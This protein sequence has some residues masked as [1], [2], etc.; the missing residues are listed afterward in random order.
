M[1]NI[2]F[3]AYVLIV[4][5]LVSLVPAAFAAPT[6]ISPNLSDATYVVG[7][8]PDNLSVGLVM[9]TTECQWQSVPVIEGS[10]VFLYMD[11]TGA[12]GTTYTPS[13]DSAE[14]RYYR[15]KMTNSAGDVSYSD[16]ALITVLNEPTISL[17][18]ASQSVPVGNAA[19]FTAAAS[20]TDGWELTH[21]YWAWGPTSNPA[22]ITGDYS[23]GGLIADTTYNKTINDPGSIYYFY[24]GEYTDTANGTKDITV[25]SNGA[26]AVGYYDNPFTDV[27]PSDWFYSD[28]LYAYNLGLI[29]GMTATTYVPDGNLTIAQSIKLAACMHQYDNT[30]AVTLVNGTVNWYDTYVDYAIGNGIISS[31]T[32]AGQYDD[33]ATRAD[34]VK[35]FY[36][37]LEPSAYTEIHTVPPGAIPD[38][39][40]TDPYGY[41]VYTFYRA[42]ILQGN[43]AN[44]TFAPDSNIKRSEV[45]AITA[46]MMDP[47]NRITTAYLWVT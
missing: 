33:D 9:I 25:Y 41:E 23:S 7:E 18:P 27:S 42:G 15:C 4:C 2:K 38:V 11:I 43:D 17:T 37:A 40:I 44:G 47:A 45:A 32:Y 13:T 20:D 28:V 46:R 35:I 31:S 1:K 29:D 24:V 16:A 22:D 19:T 6:I 26:Q 36:Y 8:T 12:T 10:M 39:A 21:S 3:T 30:G 14:T 34:Y 5:L